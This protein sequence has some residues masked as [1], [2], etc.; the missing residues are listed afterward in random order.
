MMGHF[1]SLQE[2]VIQWL[3]G[4][5]CSSNATNDAISHILII[6]TSLAF[7]TSTLNLCVMSQPAFICSNSTIETPEQYVKF[8]ETLK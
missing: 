2:A 7:D 5:T 4:Q 6:N 1:K 8:V 3:E